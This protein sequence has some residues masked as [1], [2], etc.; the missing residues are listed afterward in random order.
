ML[1]QGYILLTAAII[2]SSIATLAAISLLYIS[3]GFS[4]NNKSLEY[5]NQVKALANACGELAVQKLVTSSSFAGAVNNQIGAGSCTY[6]ITNPT[7]GSAVA[8]V[9]ATAGS[10]TRKLQIN[11]NLTPLSLTKWQEIP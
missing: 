8:D 3:T 11:F 10:A 1:Q 6:T 2:I 9:T 5:S 4:K 7:A